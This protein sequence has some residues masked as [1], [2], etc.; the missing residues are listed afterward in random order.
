MLGVML[1]LV[2]RDYQPVRSEVSERVIRLSFRPL[3]QTGTPGQRREAVDSLIPRIASQPEVI[4]VVP[5]A[6]AFTLRKI[7]E[8]HAADGVAPADTAPTT[9]NVEG[10]APGWFALQDVPILL[11]RDVSLADTA[12]RNWPVVI[13][14]N[15]SRTLWGDANPIGRT[16]PSPAWPGRTDSVSMSVVGVYD[17]TQTNTRGNS[18]SRVYTAYDKQWR[19]DVLLVRTRGSAEAFMPALQVF[20]R[21]QA[22]GLPVSRIRTIAQI[23]AQERLVTLRVAALAGSGGAVALL[24]ASLGLYGVIG[25]AVQQRTREIGIRIS[26]GANPMRVA[27][28]FLASGVRL[29]SVAL[30]IGLPLSLVA[31][32]VA[33][34]L[35][36]VH[37]GRVNMW[38]IGGGIAAALLA[39]A[40][41]ATWLPARR[42]ARVDP[43][44][45]L[46]TE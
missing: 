12:E 23:D 6:T 9:L 29:G 25:L 44:I 3:T 30:A 11:G 33:L 18:V 36:V 7:I 41:A 5:E 35:R 40:S 17:E 8:P 31:L 21:A 43:A 28:M 27:R 46:R 45:T 37:I 14:S 15:L 10:A 22:P 1:S 34:S 20:V 24:L 38:L 42:A 32:R 13:G 19:R 4:G 39:V 26:V 16:L 2:V